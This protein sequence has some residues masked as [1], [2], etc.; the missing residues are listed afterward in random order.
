LE[1]FY[2]FLM[3]DIIK[4]AKITDSLRELL[5]ENDSYAITSEWCHSTSLEFI[6]AVQKKLGGQIADCSPEGIGWY[7]NF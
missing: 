6:R 7:L 4:I 3:Y 2:S 1:P 5:A